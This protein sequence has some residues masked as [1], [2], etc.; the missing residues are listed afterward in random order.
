M[1]QDISFNEDMKKF[2]QNELKANRSSGTYI[3]YG[4]D[5]DQLLDISLVFA[6]GLCCPEKE[7]DFCGQCN[8]CNKIDKIVYS[9]LEIIENPT[10]IK[11][12]MVRDLIQKASTSSFEGDKKIFILKDIQ[13][14]KKEAS[15]ALLKLIEE[16]SKGNFFIML[17]NSLNILPT[18]KSRSIIFNVKLKTPEELDISPVIYKFFRGNSEDIAKYKE[19]GLSINTQVSFDTIGIHLK[20]YVDN[21]DFSSKV[22]VFLAI[23]DFIDNRLYI[24]IQDKMYFSEEILRNGGTREAYKEIIS[25]TI[26]C[27]GYSDGVE[28]RLALKGTMR[29]PVNMKVVLTNFFIN[30]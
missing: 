18:I 23:R 19:L 16:P 10:G 25:Y 9:D 22:N 4:K 7:N 29:Y 11:V 5:E 21:D 17:T 27:M 8:T 3:F 26:D 28:E 24:S 15:N 1:I 6:K 2:L 14:M 13:N 30:L 12:D 20:K